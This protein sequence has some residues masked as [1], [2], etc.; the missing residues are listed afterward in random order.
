MSD[1]QRGR[2][3]R[4]NLAQ[5]GFAPTLEQMTY[6]MM[7]TIELLSQNPVDKRTPEKSLPEQREYRSG[8]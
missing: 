8:H 4:Q 1:H 5:D 2:Q 6:D 7:S 3:F